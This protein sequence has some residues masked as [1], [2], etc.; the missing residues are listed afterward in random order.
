MSGSGK[1][2]SLTVVSRHLSSRR[3]TSSPPPSG[4]DN[5][6]CLVDCIA[7]EATADAKTNFHQ[8]MSST[9]LA[10]KASCVQDCIAPFHWDECK[11]GSLLGSGGFSDVYEIKSFN[12]EDDLIQSS[13]ATGVSSEEMEQ[14]LYMKNCEKHCQTKKASYALKHIRRPDLETQYGREKYFQSAR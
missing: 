14:R 12:L 11:L 13:S 3:L 6:S 5:Y 10:E 9:L 1:K 4:A 2:V 7:S 8:E